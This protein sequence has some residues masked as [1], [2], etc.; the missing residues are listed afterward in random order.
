MRA[1]GH[2]DETEEVEALKK[3][4]PDA[5]TSQSLDRSYFNRVFDE[6]EELSDRYDFTLGGNIRIYTYLDPR[7]RKYLESL[8]NLSETDKTYSVLD[9]KTHGFK[10]YYSTVGEI[11]RLPA[12]SSSRS[13]STRPLWKKILSPPPR[14]S[15]TK[16]PTS[17]AT[18]QE[19]R[20]LVQRLSQRARVPFQKRERARG[21]DTQFDGRRKIRGVYEK[22]GTGNFRGRLFGSRWRSAA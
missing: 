1:R 7:L 19:L 11:K 16:G 21:Q 12:L 18:S 4:L 14:R 9:S 5:P 10:A 2:I 20:R 6:L 22:D 8:E 17:R 15:S 13:W 3:P